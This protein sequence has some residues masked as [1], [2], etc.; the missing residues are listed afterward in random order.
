MTMTGGESTTSLKAA[1][2]GT[3]LL[4]R[5]WPTTGDPWA[6]ML[7]VH[8]AGEHSGRY[9]RTGGL[10][11]D[12]GI[13]VTAF[14]LRG[15]G[16]SG[17]RRGDVERWDDFLDDV[18]SMLDTVRYDASGPA[19]ETPVI[20]LGHSMGGLICT[21]EVLSGRAAPDLLV[22]S[23][24]ALG[25]GLPGWQHAIGPVMARIF[26][27][28]AIKNSWG[29]EALSR[30]PE[31]GRLARE[32]A[33]S[34]QSGTVRLGAGAFAAQTR[35]NELLPRLHVRTYVFHGEDDSLVPASASAPFEGLPGVT[36]RLY[37]G[38][39]HETMN[40]P[41]GPQVVADVIAWLRAAVADLAVTTPS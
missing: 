19:A 20:L 12:A 16:G 9:E 14:D 26:P 18:A 8:G 30:D 13:D 6:R 27:T 15:C 24:P 34:P 28:L 2:D 35:V 38:L 31:V 37:P 32:D 36:R 10:F 7:I 23:S 21:D 5:R 1:M 40:E 17:G 29:P 3:Q 4:V 25:D 22:L 33:G 41:E 39:R 11:A